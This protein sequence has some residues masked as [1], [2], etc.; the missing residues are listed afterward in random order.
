MRK[1]LIS[2]AVAAGA[3]TIATPAVSQWRQASPAYGA[4]Y[5]HAYGYGHNTHGQVRALQV[6]IDRLQ[7][8]IRRLDRRNIINNREAARLMNDSRALERRLFRSARYGFSFQERRAVEVRLAR[9]EHRLWR[10]ASDG[11]R[12]GNQRYGERSWDRDHWDRDQD[13]RRD[14]DRDD[15][16]DD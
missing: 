2:A 1:F 8:E 7:R 4:P 13:R 9:L 6:R 15:D 12:W 14:R 11:R 10:A 3:L 5:G 16:D